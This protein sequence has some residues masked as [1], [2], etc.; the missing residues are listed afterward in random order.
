MQQPQQH[1]PSVLERLQSGANWLYLLCR[2]IA[3]MAEVS[4]LRTGFGERHLGLHAFLAVPLLMVYAAAWPAHD[5]RPLLAYLALYLVMCLVARAES[6]S[7]RLRGR[8]EHSRYGGLPR[9]ARLMPRLSEVTIK[10]VVEPLLVLLLAMVITPLNE[11]L[12]TYL[13]LTAF[14]LCI[15]VNMTAAYDHVRAVDMHDALL[16]Q[17]QLTERFRAM[18]G[19]RLPHHERNL[20]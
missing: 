20:P 7:R 18:R 8:R 4:F 11:P 9:I 15:S 19:E 6:L 17:Q 2:A 1:E 12:G 5:P 3:V 16:E 13:L 10:R 14:A